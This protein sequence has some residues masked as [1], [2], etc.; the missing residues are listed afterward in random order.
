MQD[1]MD[2]LLAHGTWDLI[3]PNDAIIAG[4]KSI[5]TIKYDLNVVVE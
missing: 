1:E 3:F 4:C 2:T 5:Y